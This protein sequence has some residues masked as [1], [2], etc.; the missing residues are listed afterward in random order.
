MRVHHLNCTCTCPLGG[1][2]MDGRT[3]CV[4]CRGELAC[5]CLL[6]ET[7]ANGLVLVDTG[8][9]LR[10]VKSPRS[11]LSAFF[12]AMV[13]PALSEYM[14]AA[15]H[16][17]RLGFQIEDVRHIVLTHLDFDHAGGLDDFP[18]A[19]VHL[20]EKEWITASGRRSWLDAQRF[21]PAQWSAPESWRR[22][23]GAGGVGWK[24]FDGVWPI[25]GLGDE[26]ALVP[27]PGHTLGHAGVAVREQAGWKLLAGDAYFF[28]GEMDLREPYCTPGLR[29]Y[30]W[31][32]EQ[33]RRS[34]LENQSRLRDLKRASGTA[35]QV[36]CSHDM[37][38]LQAH[39]QG[40]DR[41]HR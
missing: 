37:V 1:R 10:D 11:R 28:H 22:Y 13:K 14:T 35:V 4:L 8:F 12:R 26:V 7:D 32:M 19:T 30:Q 3:R 20:M 16:V 5:H 24:G 34:R 2:L 27:L 25:D 23:G 6:V 40:V 41:R 17:S 38:E 9:G 15:H 29:F 31:M 36:F 21:R 33:D 18:G 39:Q